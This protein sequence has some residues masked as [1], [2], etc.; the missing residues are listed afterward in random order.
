MEKWYIYTITFQGKVMYVGVTNDFKRR[1]EQ[2]LYTNT[3]TSIP[4][5]IDRCLTSVDL[6]GEVYDRKTAYQIEDYYIHRYKT[7][8]NG[9]NKVRSGLVSKD[10]HYND[11]YR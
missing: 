8:E 6:I 5:D 3:L 9:W 4:K 7:I 1:R 2:H 10:P 11:K